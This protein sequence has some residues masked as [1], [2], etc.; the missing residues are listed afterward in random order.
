MVSPE[1]DPIGQKFPVEV[2]ET[3]VG[4]ATQGKERGVTDKV[5]VV[6]VV[7]VMPR[8]ES[9]KW[10][11]RDPNLLSGPLAH[12]LRR[13]W[14]R[15][16]CG[17]TPVAS[18]SGPQAGDAGTIRDGECGA[19]CRSTDGRVDRLRTA[20]HAG[21]PSQRCRRPWGPREDRQAPSDD[22][23][24]AREPGCL[25]LGNAPRSQPDA[26]ARLSQR[27]CLSV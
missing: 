3:F 13:A 26:L 20:D 12:A 8:R 15:H 22:P 24:H 1:R 6:G 21:L 27:V 9:D 18:R 23:Y 25:A 5:P 10:G 17:L 19:K 2:D 4:G 14:T 16:S 11:G 7:E